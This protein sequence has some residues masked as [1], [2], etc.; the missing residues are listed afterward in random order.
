LRSWRN[1]RAP[2]DSVPSPGSLSA[3]RAWN[4]PAGELRLCALPARAPR[5][6][7]S[8]VTSTPTASARW[9]CSMDSP[10]RGDVNLWTRVHLPLSA[11]SESV[12]VDSEQPARTSGA[13]S[14]SGAGC[15]DENTLPADLPHS[16]VRTC[17][18]SPLLDAS[19]SAG[20]CGARIAVRG[21]SGCRTGEPPHSARRRGDESRSRAGGPAPAPKKKLETFALGSPPVDPRSWRRSGD[22]SYHGLVACF[23]GSPFVWKF[24]RRVALCEPDEEKELL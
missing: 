21:C 23:V 12:G 4:E 11:A 16:P 17:W 18:R 13:G 10:A 6:G 2:D 15:G 19:E 1:L 7:G 20:S 8:W 14:S 9:S 22:T 3:P 24:G 5:G